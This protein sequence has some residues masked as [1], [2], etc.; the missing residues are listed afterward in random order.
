[1]AKIADFRRSHVGP[2]STMTVS[3][4]TSISN[5]HGKCTE[6]W[7]QLNEMVG[8]EKWVAC[9]YGEDG[10]HEAILSKKSMRMRPNA[11]LLIQRKRMEQ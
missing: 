8:A 11:P 6:K 7:T 4:P 5:S 1:M 10:R 9:F 3:K 2:P